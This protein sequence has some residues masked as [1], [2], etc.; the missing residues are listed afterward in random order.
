MVDTGR[1]SSLSYLLGGQQPVIE[2]HGDVV[3][4]CLQMVG[5]AAWGRGASSSSASAPVVRAARSTLR[6]AICGGA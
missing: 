5:V 1:R 6:L 3:H 4:R 2:W